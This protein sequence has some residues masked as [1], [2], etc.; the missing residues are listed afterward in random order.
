ML[1]QKDA[2]KGGLTM[3]KEIVEQIQWEMERKKVF[4]EI[5][6]I[7]EIDEKIIFLGTNGI[8]GEY[9]KLFWEDF[10]VKLVVYNYRDVVVVENIF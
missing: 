3:K 9:Y 7:R 8:G 10:E 2:S 6:S 5:P 4:R 1:R